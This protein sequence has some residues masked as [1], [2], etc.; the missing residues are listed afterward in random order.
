[1]QVA[2]F[3]FYGIL[4]IT[5]FAFA[6]FAVKHALQCCYIS[7]RIRPIIWI[8]V[9]VSLVLIGVS[10]YFITNFQFE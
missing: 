5:F 7:P 8:F 10:F 3:I 6:G 1:V 9:L 4:L 2:T